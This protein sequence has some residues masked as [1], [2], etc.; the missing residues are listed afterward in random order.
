MTPALT[1]ASLSL[2]MIGANEKPQ[3]SL[4]LRTILLEVQPAIPCIGGWVLPAFGIKKV[5]RHPPADHTRS[6]TAR[7]LRGA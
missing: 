3:A 5:L 2:H 4:V 7:P 6:P 1:F